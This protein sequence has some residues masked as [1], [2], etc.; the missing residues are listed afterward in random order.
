MYLFA[1]P[2]VTQDYNIVPELPFVS[3]VSH[4]LM[5]IF[6]VP[7]K[8]ILEAPFISWDGTSMH[9]SSRV[10]GYL[11][12]QEDFRV[13]PMPSGGMKNPDHVWLPWI[14]SGIVIQANL[15]NMD[16]VKMSLETLSLVL[17]GCGSPAFLRYNQN[18]SRNLS[19]FR[20]IRYMLTKV[21]FRLLGA[22]GNGTMQPWSSQILLW[23]QWIN[24]YQH[25]YTLRLPT[26][27]CVQPRMR[28]ILMPNL[29]SSSCER[30]GH[31]GLLQL[32]GLMI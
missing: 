20:K 12:L 18:L 27:W 29:L 3:K 1:Q 17:S 32:L 21:R 28:L 31:T 4:L 26:S 22:F 11:L 19:L 14:V 9:P 25:L 10:P 30:N 5:V 2:V 15:P 7:N 8:T 24:Q 16:S 23:N 13:M 6:L